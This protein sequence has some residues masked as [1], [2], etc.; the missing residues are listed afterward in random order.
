[1][2]AFPLN[3]ASISETKQRLETFGHDRPWRRQQKEKWAQLAVRLKL[4]LTK[5]VYNRSIYNWSFLLLSA[6]IVWQCFGAASM[7][8]EMAEITLSARMR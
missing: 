6:L 4:K 1:M 5:F 7:Q 3:A 2:M 8:P